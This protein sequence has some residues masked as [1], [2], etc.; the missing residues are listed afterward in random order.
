[1]SVNS[2]F[3]EQ[4]VLTCW[5]EIALYLGKGI[6][7][8]QRWEQEFGLPVRRPKGVAH[9]SAVTA[10]KEDLDAW[11]DSNWSARRE[12]GGKPNVAD[13]N[14]LVRTARQ[15]RSTHLVL[16]QQTSVA[17]ETLVETCNEL[18]QTRRKARAMGG[19]GALEVVL[20]PPAPLP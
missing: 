16:V 2:V 8:V 17:L 5:K 7:T 15:L 12:N 6:R 4:A 13:M 9:K 1:M 11:L 20:P 3:P 14:E 19:E 10:K 18:E